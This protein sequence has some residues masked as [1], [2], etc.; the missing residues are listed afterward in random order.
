MLL[1][2]IMG[3]APMAH[4]DDYDHLRAQQ[5]Q[6]AGKILPLENFIASAR[7]IYP[8]SKV[9]EIDLEEKQGIYLYEIE[10]V[11]QSGI[12]RELYFNA[13]TGDLLNTK[14]GGD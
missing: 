6:N 9:L 3:A 10:I 12:V 5:L 8:K 14:E 13:T 4:A 2:L 1:I 7:K 11:D